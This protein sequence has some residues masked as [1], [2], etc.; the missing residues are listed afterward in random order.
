MIIRPA[1]PEDNEAILNIFME[2]I[3]A[4]ETFA[5]PREWSRA[6]ALSFWYGEGSRVFVSEEGGQILGS[7]YLKPNHLG[8]GS[9]VANAGYIVASGARGQHLGRA[10]A[11]HS[12]AEAQRLGFWAMQFNFVVATNT[13]ALR[14][15]RQ[16]GFEIVG[17]LPGAFQH[18][19][20]GYVDAHVMFRQLEGG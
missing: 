20:E 10:M 18:P 8:S 13:P 17:T 1:A 15:W 5:L 3:A 6:E 7:Y 4:G 9:H 16:L 2:I 19:R 11:E 14:L 12:L